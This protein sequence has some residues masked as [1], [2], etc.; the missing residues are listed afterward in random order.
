[1]AYSPAHNKTPDALVAALRQVFDAYPEYSDPELGPG[2]FDAM[3]RKF[4]EDDFYQ[5]H[6]VARAYLGLPFQTPYVGQRV[7]DLTGDF[8]TGSILD[9]YENR[10]GG[11]V[12]VT[13]LTVDFGDD[14]VFDRLPSEVASFG[15]A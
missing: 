12:P 11:A 7:R 10:L 4:A 8:D 6:L 14:Q 3:V 9:I 1:M 13:M 2:A 15:N 5:L